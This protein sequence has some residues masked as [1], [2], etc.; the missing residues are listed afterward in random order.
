MY[1]RVSIGC[2]KNIPGVEKVDFLDIK[3][4]P[5]GLEVDLKG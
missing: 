3:E 4:D 5:L 2:D 1:A